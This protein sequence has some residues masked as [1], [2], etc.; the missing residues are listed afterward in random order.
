MFHSYR[1]LHYFNSL[2]TPLYSLPISINSLFNLL[3]RP[4]NLHIPYPYIILYLPPPV[5]ILLMLPSQLI[6]DLVDVDPDL[7]ALSLDH[8]ELL[9]QL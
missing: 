5:Y 9:L 3:Q 8:I 6:I 1:L 7:S 2:L 4:L